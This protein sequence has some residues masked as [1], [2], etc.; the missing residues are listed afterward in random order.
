LFT[1][2]CLAILMFS[3][4]IRRRVPSIHVHLQGE[5]PEGVAV[6]L[7]YH[8]GEGKPLAGCQLFR[9][10]LLNR[11]QEDSELG[12]ADKN[13]AVPAAVAKVSKGKAVVAKARRSAANIPLGR[14]QTSGRLPSLSRISSQQMSRGL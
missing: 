7:I 8:F 6:G 11:C 3:E 5:L 9:K 14:R 1:L 12:W 4:Q 13:V 10:Y 2:L